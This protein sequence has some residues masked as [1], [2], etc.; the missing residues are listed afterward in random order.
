M[1]LDALS[2]KR[3]LCLHIPSK[4]L[5]RRDPQTSTC[6]FH[7]TLVTLSEHPLSEFTVLDG[8]M[9]VIFRLS[10]FVCVQPADWT[11]HKDAYRHLTMEYHH[12]TTS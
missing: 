4:S 1:I 5:L 12:R 6:M 10:L 9:P 8:E 7:G 3:Y 2:A 11:Y